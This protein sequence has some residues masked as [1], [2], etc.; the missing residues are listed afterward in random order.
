MNVSGATATQKDSASV[1]DDERVAGIIDGTNTGMME[2]RL[3]YIETALKARDDAHMLTKINEMREI[4][5]DV[6]HETH[7]VFARAVGD[8]LTARSDVDDSS[9]ASEVA[10]RQNE[11]LVLVYP[12]RRIFSSDDVPS[13]FMRRKTVHSDTGQLCYEW[14]CVENSSGDRLVTNFS[15]TG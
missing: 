5:M 10:V 8:T 9:T 1:I 13:V 7:H 2:R 4:I 3:Q 15:L 12:M 6:C 14:I 11:T